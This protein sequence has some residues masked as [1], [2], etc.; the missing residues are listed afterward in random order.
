MVKTRLIGLCGALMFVP[1]AV[2]AGQ[3][4][5]GLNLKGF[6][7]TE[8]SALKWENNPFV[9]TT[10]AVGV[11]EL[12]LT[13]IV[14]KPGHAA[15]LLNGHVLKEG[16]RLGDVTVVHIE[17]SKVVLRSAGGLFSMNLGGVNK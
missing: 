8:S 17:P 11:Q 16:E 7:S 10:N 6:E 9:K 13:A 14:Y 5:S 12:A 2:H 1:C 15:I 3:P 4:L